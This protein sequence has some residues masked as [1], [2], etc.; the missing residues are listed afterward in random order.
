MV[1]WRL[2]LLVQDWMHI[3]PAALAC[4]TLAAVKA[5]D[6]PIFARLW[7][8]TW[9]PKNLK[10]LRKDG[11]TFELNMWNHLPNILLDLEIL[12]DYFFLRFLTW[13]CK[14]HADSMVKRSS[15]WP[16]MAASNHLARRPAKGLG[17]AVELFLLDQN[18]QNSTVWCWNLK[19]VWKKQQT[20]ANWYMKKWTCLSKVNGFQ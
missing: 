3:P 1:G 6:A 7:M 14:T 9:N 5:I 8:L 20:S 4:G 19:S 10:N 16:S 12:E 17:S 15:V 18:H 13:Q 11:V 2:A